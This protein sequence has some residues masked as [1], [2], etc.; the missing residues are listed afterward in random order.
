ML[1]LKVGTVLYIYYFRL[2]KHTFSLFHFFLYPET[3]FNYLENS[4]IQ[5][6]SGFIDYIVIINVSIDITPTE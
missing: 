6:E 2:K 1:S 5:S 3:R 4:L